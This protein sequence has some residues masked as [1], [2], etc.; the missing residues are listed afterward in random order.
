MALIHLFVSALNAINTF[1]GTSGGAFRQLS[2][3]TP[4]GLIIVVFYCTYSTYAQL[5]QNDDVS[6]QQHVACDVAPHNHVEW[7]KLFLAI[8]P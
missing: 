3:G 6:T 8:Q 5:E 7:G 4:K 1:I 2:L